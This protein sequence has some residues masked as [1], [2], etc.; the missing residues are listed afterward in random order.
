MKLALNAVK[1][2]LN[3]QTHYVHY[4][5]HG[6]PPHY[7]CPIYENLCAILALFKT[8]EKEEVEKGIEWLSR[9]LHF[10]NNDGFFPVYL[11]E[12]PAVK[13][14][15]AGVYHL[16]PLMQ[17][18]ENFKQV[19][20]F[21]ERLKTSIET[22]KSA[23]KTF[24]LQKKP[25]GFIAYQLAQLM[26]EIGPVSLDFPRW[27][28]STHLA[29]R[30]LHK[31]GY[32]WLEKVW[33]TPSGQYVGPS[34]RE[35]QEGYLPEI[36]SLH[37]IL[38]VHPEKLSPH[39]IQASLFSEVIKPPEFKPLDLHEETDGFRWGVRQR[40][41]Y[42]F[43]VLDKKEPSSVYVQPGCQ[44]LRFI[45]DSHSLVLEG[46]DV[47]RCFFELTEKGVDLFL[48]LPS[49]VDLDDREKQR[50]ITF[51]CDDKTQVHPEKGRS[52]LFYLEDPILF[53]M[54]DLIVK[55]TFSLF[56]G[57]GDFAGHL[58]KENRPSQIIKNQTFDRGVLLRTLRRDS[59]VVLKASLTV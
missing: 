46:A 40:E 11:H 34:F 12:Y 44:L 4:Y 43:S 17:I 53:K 35:R 7:T 31:E 22:L 19:I 3:P 52:T 30:L 5:Y 10:Q 49:S 41:N 36:T 48:T 57:N 59:N 27:M 32:E 33:H 56:E 29:E 50:E 1:Q 23:L 9:L 16:K 28:G 26:P 51:Y 15:M 24:Y 42:A 2:F 37:L 14:P 58:V 18:E 8:R 55:L 25:Q 21:R 47:D 6:E 54:D 20:P 38:G 39:H 45:S 13:D